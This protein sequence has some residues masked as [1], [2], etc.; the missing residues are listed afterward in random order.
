MRLLERIRQHS[1]DQPQTVA[2][3]DDRQ[4]LTYAALQNAI[5]SRARILS[6]LHAESVILTGSNS[7][8]WVVWD[9]ACLSA[10]VTNTPL[11]AF[12]SMQQREHVLAQTGARFILDADTDSVNGL[13]A[14]NRAA[15]VM[16]DGTI[17]VTF[18]SGSTGHPKGVCLS[19]AS[20]DSTTAALAQTIGQMGVHSHMAVLPLATLLE[21]VAGVYLPLWLGAR[22]LLPSQDRLGFS[23]TRLD[24][25]RFIKALTEHAPE[26]L[27]LVPELLN[28]L[29]K[30]ADLGLPLPDTL[31]LIAVGGGKISTDLLDRAALHG[32]PV[33]EGYGLSEACSVVALST[34]ACRA[35]G[36]SGTLLPHIEARVDAQQHL[37]L[38][39][40]SLMLGYLGEDAR[41]Q[42]WLDT[43]DLASID[44]AGRL[45]VRGRSKNLII[46]SWGRNI[47]PEWVE[48][49]LVAEA[50]ILQAMVLGEA[51]DGLSAIICS[52]P[53]ISD[54]RIREAITRANS[55]LPD[56]ARIVRWSPAEAPFSHENHMLTGNG[57][58]RREAIESH[59]QAKSFKPVRLPA[60]PS[61][62]P[63]APLKENCA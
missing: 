53:G 33:F 2:L 7:A 51:T 32:L 48:S 34:P 24:L 18:T 12:F 55:R 42:A 54:D 43:G 17:K 15:P 36:S 1:L 30:A 10:G 45:Y 35:P 5:V 23:G 60:N 26:S 14:S 37:W 4:T 62:P 49:E 9:L 8:S 41:Q 50:V 13:S 19:A 6:D 27:I 3:S 58:L 56:Y 57:R 46:T 21:N 11:P 61:S 39:A 59:Y 38:R 63:H 22:T 44:E 29:V 28:A 40:D 20:L 47:H 16:P 52:L 25:F 31:K